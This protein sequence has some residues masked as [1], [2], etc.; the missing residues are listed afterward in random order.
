[1]IINSPYRAL[2]DI[3][4]LIGVSP[5]SVCKKVKTKFGFKC[6]S[7]KLMEY[8]RTRYPWIETIPNTRFIWNLSELGYSD[9]IRISTIVYQSEWEDDET[10]ITASTVKSK[11]LKLL[12]LKIDVAM[13]HPEDVSLGGISQAIA[14][15]DKMEQDTD[16][17]A[18]LEDIIDNDEALQVV[19]KGTEYDNSKDEGD[20]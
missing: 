13:E 8:R 3:N 16:N 7:G 5:Y 15:L 2:I 19:F 10:P 14:T 6:S 1:M 9:F 4:L 18:P 11:G 12:D 17:L 20:T